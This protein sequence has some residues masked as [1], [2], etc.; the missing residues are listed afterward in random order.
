VAVLPALLVG[1]LFTPLGHWLAW[2][3]NSLWQGF[4]LL[5]GIA[6]ARQHL[7]QQE[8]QPVSPEPTAST[9]SAAIRE[10]LYSGYTLQEAGR[11][12]EALRHY[13]EALQA[14]DRY[15]PTLVALASAYMQLGREDDA[16]REMERAAELAPDNAFVLG[17]LGFLYL[18]RREFEQSI[19]ML[20]RAKAAA[21]DEAPIRLW[22]GKAYHF[23]SLAD[24]EKAVVELERG[25]ELAPQSGD[26]HYRLALSYMRREDPSDSQRAIQSLQRTIELDPG[27]ADAYYHLGLLH[28]QANEWEA[29]IEAWHSYV[30]LSDDQESVQR[31]RGW[32]RNL[33]ERRDSAPAPIP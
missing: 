3:A 20:E 30:D 28:A 19:A 10:M 16:L 4:T 25:A 17:Q 14:D 2:G 32:L 18:R 1:L 12:E 21:P 22:L 6:W 13:R 8:A 9:G 24:A 29:A 26:I 15:P 23:R 31:V 33:K 27:Y 5:P 11:L 7:E